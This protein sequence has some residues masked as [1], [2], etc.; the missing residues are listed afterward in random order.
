MISYNHNR[1]ILIKWLCFQP[2]HKIH[3]LSASAGHHVCILIAR[4][5]ILAQI[6]N[7]SIFKMGVNSQHRKVKWLSAVSQIEGD[8]L[9][10]GTNLFSAEPALAEKVGMDTLNKEIRKRS[11]FYEQIAGKENIDDSVMDMD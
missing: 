2:V 6:T 8:R 5:F 11:I 1:G 9:G 3:D 4:M 10:L 7:I